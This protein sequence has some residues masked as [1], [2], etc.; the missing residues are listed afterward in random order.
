MYKG[1]SLLNDLNNY[2]LRADI[3]LASTL[4]LNGT[5]FYGKSYGD[6]GV[7]N[8]GHE[9]SLL[10]DIPHGASLS[11]VFPAWLKLHN[12]RI[13]EKIILLGKELFNVSSVNETIENFEHFYASIGSPIHLSDFIS[14]YKKQIILEQFKM[15]KVSGSNLKLNEADYIELL[16][17]II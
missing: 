1:K 14:D 8:L 3:M 13:P 4:G 15:N 16:E 17:F 11:M 7:H 2:D 5:T 9:L 6:W 10:Y 12:N